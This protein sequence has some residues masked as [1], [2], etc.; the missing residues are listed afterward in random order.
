MNTL[1]KKILAPKNIEYLTINSELRIVELSWGVAR[2]ADCPEQ[3]RSGEDVCDA[4]PEL[5]GLEET[6][7]KIINHQINQFEIKGIC[8]GLKEEEIIYFDIYVLNN[9]EN[10]LNH[11]ELLI[12]L[13]DTTEWVL[14]E[15]KIT[16]VAKEYGLALSALDKTKTY[17]N[18]II[19]SM[20]DLLIVTDHQGI[21]KIINKATIILFKYSQEE[22]IQHSIFK[23]FENKKITHNFKESEFLASFHLLNPIEILCK[24]KTGTSFPISFSCSSLNF[25]IS[26]NQEFVW[27]GRDMTEQ[28]RVEFQFRQQGERDRLLKTITQRIHQSLSLQETL[29]TIVGE[30]RHFL[31]VDRVL[32]YR[33]FTPTEGRIIAETVINSSIP[34][35]NPSI[36]TPDFNFLLLSYF[37]SGKIDAIEDVYLIPINF[38]YLYSLLQLKVKA[39]LVVPI[40]IYDSSQESNSTNQVWGLLMAHQCYQPR[41]W[42][43]W[44]I[45]LLEELATQIA[46][47]LQQAELYEQLQIAYQ[48]LQQLVIQ[49]GLTGLANR[50]HFDRVL[51][52]EWN[53]L[54]REGSPLSLLLL[55][56]DYFKQ[57]NDSY[58]HLAGDFCLQEVAQVL[59]NIVQR[60]SD[61]VARYGGEE[62]AV[63]LPNTQTSEAV[64]VAERI[65]EQVEALQIPHRESEVS[66][67]VTMSIG[68]ATLIPIEHLT[69]QIVIH[70][71]DQALY[72]AKQNGRN[73]I[74]IASP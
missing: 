46:I 51:Y 59:Q 62:F 69:P 60:S 36:L 14:K 47:A 68:V 56:I 32:I 19:N 64:E 17:L 30:I 15:Q 61:L 16:Q 71:A 48:G 12:V 24:A 8:R 41:H 38:P 63:I 74:C 50:R 45:N 10:P 7:K 40:L 6:F 35:L 31:Q 9:P 23:L 28:K 26:E 42:E 58:G 72:Q 34:P 54:R 5:I 49:D 2:F 27:I 57:Y 39:S 11:E 33:F 43:V 1:L 29:Q 21:I 52:Q 73:S 65:R 25:D 70:T 44:E 13:E 22:L 4:F 18:Q 37:N 20:T 53:R 67:Y 66:N 55:D 3:V